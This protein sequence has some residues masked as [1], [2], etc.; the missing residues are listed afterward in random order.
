MKKLLAIKMNSFFLILFIGIFFLTN[1]NASNTKLRIGSSYEGEITW[2][3]LKFN[4]PDGEWIYY[5]RSGWMIYHFHGA[6]ASFNSVDKKIFNGHF[7]ICYLDSGGKLKTQLGGYLQ[8]DWKNNKYD[9]CSLRP[10]YFYA[11]SIFKGAST[12]CF[13]TRHID[14]NKELYYP[15]DPEDKNKARIKKYINDNNLIIPFTFLQ[16]ES[17]YFS[18]L[19]DKAISVSASINPEFYGASKSLYASEEKS[20]YHRNNIEDHP[21]KKEFMLRWTKKMSEE[22]QNLENQLGAK[23]GFK[24]NFSDIESA[25]N[26]KETSG[27]VEQLKKLNEMFKSGL[28]TK[29]EF[30]KAK[31]KLLN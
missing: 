11:K 1:V 24:L 15:D 27:L 6:C 31:K 9:N 8:A 4:L 21:T 29:E 16:T 17:L 25:S 20:E 12:N 23:V 28:L 7:K 19:R 22:H 18:N 3:H 2:K 30:E 26:Q 10:E 13:I 14:L 5:D